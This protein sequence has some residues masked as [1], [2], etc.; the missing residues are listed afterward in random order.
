[1]K[2]NI[3]ISD[4]CYRPFLGGFAMFAIFAQGKKNV[5]NKGLV[6]TK[7]EIEAKIKEH[8][9]E[10]AARLGKVFVIEGEPK[11]CKPKTEYS[12]EDVSVEELNKSLRL[13][14]QGG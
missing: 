14:Q 1:M 7:E 13:L 6:K 8:H 11:L 2:N 3:S 12:M 5:L 10:T 9:L 4:T